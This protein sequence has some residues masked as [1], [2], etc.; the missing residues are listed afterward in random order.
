M[1][2]AQGARN[3]RRWAGAEAGLAHRS[4]LDERKRDE[5]KR[6]ACLRAGIRLV[7]WRY[8]EPVSVGA[9]RGRL[10]L[11]DG[12]VFFPVGLLTGVRLIGDCTASDQCGRA[13]L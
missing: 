7:E 5:R 12:Q 10:G 9:V 6:D 13:R 8:D 2:P 3:S 4:E 1:G 11:P